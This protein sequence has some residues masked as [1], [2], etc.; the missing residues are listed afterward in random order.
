MNVIHC[1]SSVML[2]RDNIHYLETAV[3]NITNDDEGQMKPGLKKDM[4][5]Y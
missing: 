4:S 3:E 1:D 2:K 5:T